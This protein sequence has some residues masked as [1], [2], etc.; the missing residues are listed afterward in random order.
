VSRRAAPLAVAPGHP[1]AG[2]PLLRAVAGAFVRGGAAVVIAEEGENRVRRCGPGESSPSGFVVEA[3]G[4][5]NLLHEALHWVQAG[6][7][8]EDYGIDYARIPFDTS[9][10]AQRLLLWQE[11][12]C[13][14]VSCAYIADR[15]ELVDAWFA[16]QVGIQHHFFGFASSAPFCEHVERV[17][18]RHGA[19]LDEAVE[20]AYARLAAV[21]RAE[22]PA[23]AEPPARPTFAGLW[24][25]MRA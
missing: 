25:T 10:A 18:A 5:P 16:E 23:L 22:D 4:L 13:C 3:Q 7:L 15:P 11:L 12:A 21:L 14:V 9:V 6:V 8:D 19:E 17:V 2:R 24:A 20:A 1:D